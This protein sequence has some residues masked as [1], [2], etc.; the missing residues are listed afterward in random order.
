MTTS[1]N[2]YK[3]KYVARVQSNA[4]GGGGVGEND[5]NS[6]IYSSSQ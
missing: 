2:I 5:L 6:V 1:K 4:G 3:I